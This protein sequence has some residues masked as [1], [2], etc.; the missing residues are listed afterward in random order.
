MRILL[1]VLACM[2]CTFANLI[3]IAVHDLT[4]VGLSGDD[5][6]LITERLRTEIVQS[7]LF[8]VMERSEMDLI[9]Q[10]MEFQ[11]SGACDESA[12]LV[13]LGQ[14]LGVEK[15]ISG[16]VGKI[17]EL[18][19]ISL[20]LIDVE[21][22]RIER[23]VSVDNSESV[24]NFYTTSIREISQ[25]ITSDSETTY[26]ADVDTGTQ[27]G[28]V[29]SGVS[30]LELYEKYRMDRNR[31]DGEFIWTTNERLIY[32][33]RIDSDARLYW[34]K[35]RK[36]LVTGI[37]LYSVGAGLIIS[38]TSVAENNETVGGI[39][40]GTGVVCFS[41]SVIPFIQS[42]VNHNIGRNEYN[43]DLREYYSN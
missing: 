17:G 42:L 10:E 12:C 26:I 9:V 15:I 34:K 39:M 18:Y 32:S 11:Q 29:L 19:T 24:E 25:K 5:A 40:E 30:N 37:I 28:V 13:E 21:T 3:N 31:I 1:L 38:G 41:V 8:D 7:E 33:D 20:K 35:S 4:P 23:S 16:T 27:Q 14:I 6:I 2:T 43:S 36:K 22:A